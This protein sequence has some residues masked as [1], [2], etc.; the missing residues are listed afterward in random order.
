[1]DP[2]KLIEIL[3]L[4]PHPEGGFYKETY[5]ALST[6][7]IDNSKIRNTSTAIYYLLLDDHKSHF[8]KVLSDEIWIYH[9]GETIELY[10]IDTKGALITHLLGNDIQNSEKPQIVIPKGDWFAAKIKK[11]IGYCLVSCIVAPGFEFEDF[12]LAN[13]EDLIKQYPEYKGIISQM[14]L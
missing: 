1:M 5:R 9:Q 6:V 10:Q 3:D 11:D 13:Q 14:C 7:E 8:H 12:I 4:K 2:Y